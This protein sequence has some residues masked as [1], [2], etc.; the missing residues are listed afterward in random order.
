[1]PLSVHDR[2]G[3]VS[4]RQLLIIPEFNLSLKVAMLGKL[5]TSS[6]SSFHSLIKDGKK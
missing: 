4:L 6:V 3:Q 5:R 2:S 1:M